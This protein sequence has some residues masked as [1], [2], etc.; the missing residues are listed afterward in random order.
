MGRAAFARA[1]DGVSASRK[2]SQN[3]VVQ[4]TTTSYVSTSE[5]MS[6][7][8][9]GSE[10]QKNYLMEAAMPKI[11]LSFM[12]SQFTCF[13]MIMP[14]HTFTLITGNTKS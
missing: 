1:K 8:S 14:L 9:F 4:R 3:Q 12:G 11:S 6:G 2:T 10:L 5:K 7:L 13:I